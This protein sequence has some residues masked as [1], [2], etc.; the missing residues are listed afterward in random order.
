MV[1]DENDMLKFLVIV[2][3]GLSLHNIY[4]ATFI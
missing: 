2:I 3:F 1:C 4:Y